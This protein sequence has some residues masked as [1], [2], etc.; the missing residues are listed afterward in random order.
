MAAHLCPHCKVYADFR[1]VGTT[2]HYIVPGGSHFIWSCAN[3]SGGVFVIGDK[4]V[5]PTIRTE[6]SADIPTEIRD[7]FNEALRSLNGNNAKAA[8]IMTRSA[9]QGATRQQR[10]QGKTLKDEIDDLAAKHVISPTLQDWSHE[11]RDGGNLVAHPEPGKTVDTQDAE[12]LIAL[13]ESIFD[14]LYVIPAEVA[15]RRARQAGSTP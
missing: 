7:D 1:Q 6:A 15:R 2:V 5:Y 12:E 14:Y 10:A 9:L 3:C 4:I 11:L 13:A 8:V